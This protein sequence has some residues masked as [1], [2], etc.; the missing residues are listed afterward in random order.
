LT[1][2]APDGAPGKDSHLQ[3]WVGLIGVFGLE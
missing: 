3:L 2:G 1:G